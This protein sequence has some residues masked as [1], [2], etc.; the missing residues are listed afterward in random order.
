MPL[1]S[2]LPLTPLQS[3]LGFDYLPHR[4]HAAIELLFAFVCFAAAIALRRRRRIV[5][6]PTFMMLGLGAMI[7]LIAGSVVSNP[8][9]AG[10]FGGAAVLFF[11]WGVVRLL[12]DTV[13]YTTR[14]ARRD[15]SNILRDLISL[16]LYA[17]VLV[18]VLAADF[19]VNVYS[20]VASVGVLG[21]VIGFAV[22]QT[23]GD[24]FSG[25]A[26]QLQRPFDH[27]DWVRSGQFFGRV[28]G[29]G[30]RS[31]T[32][33]TRN[34]ERLEIPN[35]AIAKEVL[36]NYGSPPV[37]D[38]IS[39]GISYDEP[40]NRVREVILKV[41]T[42]VQHVLMDPSPEVL[43]WEYGDSAIKYRI[44]YWISDYTLQEQIRNSLVTSLWYAL[45]RNAMDIP[46][47]IQT[48]DVRSPRISGRSQ[49]QFEN[50]IIRELR[51][52]DF[53]RNMSEQE[54]RL[55]VPNVQVHEFG[56]GETL[57]TQGDTGDTMYIIRRG[58]VEIL[59]RTENGATRHIA[60]LGRPQIIGEAGMMS[61]EPRN[62][63]C[64]AQTDV[65][66]L[67]LNRESFSD[68][69]KQHPEAIEQ[70][71][72]VIANRASERKELLKDPGQNGVAARRNWWIAKVREIFDLG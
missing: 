48:I 34:N 11:F 59:G 31:T 54:V 18:G 71:S 5:T 72:E 37:C 10:A 35:S 44:K 13:D 68:L 16:S 63:T 20:L 42:D 23:L 28:Q 22:Q 26:L 7:D 67:E 65:E 53:L 21:V 29:V 58:K 38:E 2:L 50:E 56:A 49:E 19:Q 33:I 47:P 14:R 46:F 55:L 39:I 52:I 6:S 36:T 3:L 9:F 62:A 15:V 45:R 17:A 30:V 1:E 51:Q 27:G 61:G 12:M 8:K 69:F 43:A 66:V 41:L 24:I 60:V 57:F 40:P 32:V 25:L 4:Y 64:R 70:I